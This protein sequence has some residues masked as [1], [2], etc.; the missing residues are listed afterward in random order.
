[1]PELMIGSRPEPESSRERIS[2]C[3]GD[4]DDRDD[5]A[6]GGLRLARISC[7]STRIWLFAIMISSSWRSGVAAWSG[8]R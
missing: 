1:M 2:D 8:R 6:L 4:V 7:A 3:A 5:V